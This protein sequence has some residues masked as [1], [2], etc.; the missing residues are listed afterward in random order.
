MDEMQVVK[1]SV[2]LDKVAGVINWRAKKAKR[3]ILEEDLQPDPNKCE[4]LS[5]KHK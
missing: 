3:V 1:H 2:K 5:V 4:S